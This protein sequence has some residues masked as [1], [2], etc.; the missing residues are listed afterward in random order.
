M[1]IVISWKRKNMS[2]HFKYLW[3]VLKHKWYVGIECIKQGLFLRALIHDCSKFRPS[4]WFPYVNFFYGEK[5]DVRDEI[6]Y[7]KPTGTGDERFDFAWLLHQKRNDHHWQFFVLPEDEGGLKVLR[8]SKK[9]RLEMVCDWCGAS[10]AQGH[11]GWY[12]PTGVLAWYD[13]HRSKMRL[14]EET[15]R[16]VEAFLNLKRLE[17]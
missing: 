12:G 5:E 4:E 16:W 10:K 3:Y 2:K 9:A 15:R 17:R 6:G 1:V 7:Y 8:M 14:H 13:K 11:G